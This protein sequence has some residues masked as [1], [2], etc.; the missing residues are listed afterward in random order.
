VS[1]GDVFRRNLS[2]HIGPFFGPCH[3]DSRTYESSDWQVCRFGRTVPDASFKIPAFSKKA[4][5]ERL[6]TVGK[7]ASFV[8]IAWVKGAGAGSG[9][10][11]VA[12]GQL[13]ATG[14]G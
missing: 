14:D 12:C 7:A 6:L 9:W 4:S 2:P 13:L 5:A 10:F 3:R 8:R 1:S 11:P